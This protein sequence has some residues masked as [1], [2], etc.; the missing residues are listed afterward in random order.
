MQGELDEEGWRDLPSAD[1]AADLAEGGVGAGWGA[2]RGGQ[3]VSRGR[4]EG[5]R[6]D[7][8]GHEDGTKQGSVGLTPEW[9][10]E[11]LGRDHGELELQVEGHD[12]DSLATL[13]SSSRPHDDGATR[14][15]LSWSM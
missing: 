15:E 4:G 3:G 1:G 7:Q 12:V 11:T 8:S 14:K 9:H 10:L 2:E 5:G 13:D 6:Q